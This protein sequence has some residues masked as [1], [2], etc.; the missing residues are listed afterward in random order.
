MSVTYIL[1]TCEKYIP[2]RGKAIRNTWLRGVP[3]YFFLSAVPNESERVL[4]WNTPDD[5]ESCSLKYIEFFR[6]KTI[7][8][9][10][11]VLCDDDTYVFTERLEEMLRTKNPDE[12]LYIGYEFPVANPPGGFSG[13]AGIVL[14]RTAYTQLCEY[15]RST[16]DVW[17]SSYTDVSMAVWMLERLEGVQKVIDYRFYPRMCDT[18]EEFRTAFTFHY[19][20]PEKMYEY[21]RKMKHPYDISILIPTMNSRK[22]LFRKVLLEVER[23][24]RE[25]PEIRVE[26]LWEA[27]DGEITLGQKRNVLMDRCSG[28]YHCFVDDDDVLSPNYLKTFVPMILSETDYDCASF[29]GAHYKRGGFNKLFYHSMKFKDWDETEERFIR[30]ISPMNLIKTEIVRQV[31]YKDIRNTEDYEFSVRLM[32]SGLLKAEFDIDPNYPIYHYIDEVKADRE[33]WTYTWRG[34]YLYLYKS[35]TPPSAFQSQPVVQQARPAP[36]Q[37]LRISRY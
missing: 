9:D 30:T 3:N 35:F 2:T 29:V 34:D 16:D 31:R 7:D 24:I 5:Y 32:E 4:G 20:T 15:L 8:T 18:D 6:N 13:G 25:T 27:D 33:D 19:V 23:Q 1:L 10:W 22:N 11:I 21:Y 17:I 36:L 12:S 28:K 37:F 26:V 14:S